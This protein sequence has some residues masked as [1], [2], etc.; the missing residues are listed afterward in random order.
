MNLKIDMHK[1]HAASVRRPSSREYVRGYAGGSFLISFKD[2]LWFMYVVVKKPAAAATYQ[3]FL[4]K[5]DL[6][7]VVRSAVSMGCMRAAVISAIKRADWE[8]A[9]VYQKSKSFLPPMSTAEAKVI[10]VWGAT[11]FG[12]HSLSTLSQHALK[13][14]QITCLMTSYS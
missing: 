11:V 5:F 8:N 14:V 3:V 10:A 6:C 9:H 4:A 13:I 7:A 1:V 12:F 2:L